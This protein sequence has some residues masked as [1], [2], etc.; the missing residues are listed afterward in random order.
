VKNA[1]ETDRQVRGGRKAARQGRIH[2]GGIPILK[3]GGRVWGGEEKRRTK[4]EWRVRYELSDGSVSAK[5]M[6]E[7]TKGGGGGGVREG[8]RRGRGG[9]GG[10]GVGVGEEEG[11]VGEKRG[12]RERREG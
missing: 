10:W 11:G 9:G 4:K 7:V 12:S 6:W 8:G 2:P 1:G 3:R 5:R